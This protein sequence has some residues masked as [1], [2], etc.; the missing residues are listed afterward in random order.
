V[1]LERDSALTAFQVRVAQL[2]FSLPE[3]EG[4]LLAGGGALLAQGLTVRPTQDLDFFTQ[5]G[6][7]DVVKAR[8][9]LEAVASTQG[10][11]VD[12]IQDGASFC[13]LVVHGPED[14]LVDLAVDSAPDGPA[15]ASFVGP[16]FG[17]EE[18]AGRKLLALF[19]RAAARDFVDVYVLTRRFGQEVLLDRASVLDVGFERRY[20]AEML[21][22]LAR[23]EDA[24]LPIADTEIP[25]LREFF[26]HWRAELER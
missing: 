3:A 18:L 17:L 9:A 7:G 11:A 21:V 4:F 22:S 5:L 10:W 23:F 20:L 2:F 6:S 19:D 1:T 8:D 26:A 13:R 14:L 24:E 12:R 25:A 16:T 15:V